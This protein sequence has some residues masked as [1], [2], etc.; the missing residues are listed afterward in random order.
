MKI[1]PVFPQLLDSIGSLL[2][3]GALQNF[4]T[5]ASFFACFSGHTSL[6]TLYEYPNTCSSYSLEDLLV[7]GLDWER[8]VLGQRTTVTFCQLLI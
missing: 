4:G 1:F 5:F 6:V 3:K 8:V 2:A 7:D